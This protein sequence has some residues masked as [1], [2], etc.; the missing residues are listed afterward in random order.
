MSRDQSDKIDDACQNIMGHTNWSYL[1][2]P[3]S[4]DY[5]PGDVCVIFHR[6]RLDEEEKID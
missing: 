4:V 6:N 5:I 1:I 3:R 2:D